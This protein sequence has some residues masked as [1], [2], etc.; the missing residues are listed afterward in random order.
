M[1]LRNICIILTSFATF[2]L[3]GIDLSLA[4]RD[5]VMQIKLSNIYASGDNHKVV[6]YN[7]YIPITLRPIWPPIKKPVM[8]PTLP[9]FPDQTLPLTITTTKQSLLLHHSPILHNSLP[10][11]LFSTQH[12]EINTNATPKP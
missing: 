1:A 12:H 11:T 7:F 6:P 8:P 9:K 2:G 3:L 4:A 5:G 10:K